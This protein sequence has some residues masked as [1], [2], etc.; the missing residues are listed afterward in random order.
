MNEKSLEKLLNI[1]SN[2]VLPLTEKS[3]AKGNKIFG[4]AII[5][6]TYYE[7]IKFNY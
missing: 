7:Q 3:V 5:K 1:F 6:K 4:A 2:E